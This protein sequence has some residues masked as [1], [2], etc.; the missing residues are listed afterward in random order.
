MSEL[1]SK[2][3]VSRLLGAT[4]SLTGTA[5][6][7]E[8]LLTD[9][10]HRAFSLDM[11][12]NRPDLNERIRSAVELTLGQSLVGYEE[13][14]QLTNAVKRRPYAVVVGLTTASTVKG[15]LLSFQSGT[16]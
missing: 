4:V 12:S 13:G 9:R 10:C 2:H 15:Y 14:G 6:I 1:S 16:G 3:D 8:T 7:A 11:V 5:D